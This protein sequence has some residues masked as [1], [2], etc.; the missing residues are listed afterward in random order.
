MDS[1]MRCDILHISISTASVDA[2]VKWEHTM[3]ALST[4]LI[5]ILEGLGKFH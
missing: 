3:L 2:D 1:W 4:R 5:L